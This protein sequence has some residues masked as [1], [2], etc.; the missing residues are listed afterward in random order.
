[1]RRLTTTLVALGLLTAACGGSQVVQETGEAVPP[2]SPV[3]ATSPTETDD[4]PD[5]DDPTPTAAPPVTPEPVV[6]DGPPAPD[7]A[8]ALDDGSGFVLSIEP[9]PVYLVFWA[10]W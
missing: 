9:K 7:F 10:E 5:L 6:V 1:M 3:V 4:Y 2:T 8:L